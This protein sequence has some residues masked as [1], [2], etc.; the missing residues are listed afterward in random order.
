MAELRVQAQFVNYVVEDDEGH[1]IPQTAFRGETV[2]T[3]GISEREMERLHRNGAFEGD[4]RPT[5]R[6]LAAA[7]AEA[8]AQSSLLKAASLDDVPE[9]GVDPET[10]V[11]HAGPP[12]EDADGGEAL[13]EGTVA[14]ELTDEQIDGL[15]GSQLDEACAQAG[16]DTSTGGSL[17]D[18]S[19]SAAEKRAALK[20]QSNA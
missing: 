8:D 10:G 11:E 13:P 16:I 18:G 4:E 1:Q 12:D 20:E 17:S 3:A 6:S 19:M 2:D 14:S 9:P 5:N 7:Y 15:S